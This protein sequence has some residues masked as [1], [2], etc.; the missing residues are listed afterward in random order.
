MQTQCLAEFLHHTA[1]CQHTLQCGQ[2][3]SST[4]DICPK[5]RD[6]PFSQ[7][8]SLAVEGKAQFVNKALC[9]TLSTLK[10]VNNTQ[11]VSR[12]IQHTNHQRKQ[13]ILS[14]F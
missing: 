7:V 13:V 14:K 11:Q 1:S 12:E 2:S 5:S 10:G 8:Q 3:S 9:S 6:R 4:T